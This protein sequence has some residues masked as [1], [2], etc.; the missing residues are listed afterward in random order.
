MYL[1]SSLIQFFL[2]VISLNLF[3]QTNTGWLPIGLSASGKNMQNG[4]EAFYQLG[5]CNSEDIICIK[6]I[7]NNNFGVNME[8]NDAVFTM[9]HKWISNVKTEK[10]KC[11]TLGQG[12]T[13][14]GDC[15]KNKNSE[16][17]VK[18]NEFITDI[19]DFNL[20]GLNNF[21]VTSIIE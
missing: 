1:K 17:R 7:N 21:K 20:F 12:E 13:V 6:F 5:K 4:V 3:A 15:K 9:E 8:W 2:F 11:L 16:L 10:R 14:S 18:I 19:K